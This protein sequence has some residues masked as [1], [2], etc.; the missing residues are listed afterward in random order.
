[1]EVKIVVDVDVD[2]GLRFIG[3]T[4]IRGLQ[5]GRTYLHISEPF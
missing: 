3:W 2:V 1:M 4:L 5:G